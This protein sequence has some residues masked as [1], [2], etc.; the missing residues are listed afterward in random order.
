LAYAI[1]SG[2]LK[3]VGMPRQSPITRKEQI[4]ALLER[5]FV[6]PEQANGLALANFA[7]HRVDTTRIDLV[8]SFPLKAKLNG[9]IRDENWMDQSQF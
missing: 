8:R 2:E 6:R 9:S 4:A 5:N 1:E 3:R 7:K